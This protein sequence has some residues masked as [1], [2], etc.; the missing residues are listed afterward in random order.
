MKDGI[1]E[2]IRAFIAF[3]IPKPIKRAMGLMTDDLRCQ[4]LRLKWV[5][6]DNIHLTLRF[7]G[8]VPTRR[9]ESLGLAMRR[10]TVHCEPLRIGAKGVGLFPGPRHPKVLWVG[11]CGDTQRLRD[12]EK[13][14]GENLA[15]L[16]FPA[17]GKPFREHLTIG[18][19]KG[20]IVPK[21][22][23]HILDRAR[24]FESQRFTVRELIL[25]KSDLTPSGA[26]YSRILEAPLEGSAQRPSGDPRDERWTYKNHIK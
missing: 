16:G 1:K 4:G 7:M 11:V 9:V 13:Q 3:E 14:L 19:M 8:N 12:L 18:R 15:D 21:T 20:K 10:S 22:L 6:P 17:G 23:S 24:E 5:H 2:E 25:F 26:V